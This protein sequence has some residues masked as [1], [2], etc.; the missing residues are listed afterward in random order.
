MTRLFISSTNNDRLKALRRLARRRRGVPVFVAEGGRALRAAINA[1][2]EVREVYAAPELFISARDEAVVELAERRGAQVVEL[3]REAF[4]SVAIAARPDGIVSVVECWD[5][6]LDAMDDA[7][8]LLVADG[9]E[10]PGNLGTIVR[11]ACAAGA[12]GL[13]ACDAPTDVFHPETVRGSVATLFQLPVAE[14]SAG[15][16]TQWLRDRDMRI[17]VATP[18]ALV[19][20]WEA[21][22]AGACAIVVGSERYGVREEW[23]AA[24]AATVQIPMAGAADSVNVAVAA[25]IVLF[26]A[27]RQRAGATYAPS[28]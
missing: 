26:E 3:G 5:T 22:Y 14:A 10:R 25:G 28:R 12:G 1:R 19:P 7:S 23:L 16:A 15:C 11:T 4:E 20:Y 8:L 2:K 9:I 17:V 18:D 21:D 6:S 13:V 24:A 27:A